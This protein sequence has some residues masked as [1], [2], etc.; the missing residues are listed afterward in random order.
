MDLWV[1]DIFEIHLELEPHFM[2][3]VELKINHRPKLFK[4]YMYINNILFYLLSRKF[5][6]QFPINYL[7]FALGWIFVLNHIIL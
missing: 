4:D 6:I 3:V 1:F 5:T 2:K 7:K